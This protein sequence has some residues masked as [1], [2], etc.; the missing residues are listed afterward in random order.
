MWK[1]KYLKIHIHRSGCVTLDAFAS[2]SGCGA[3]AAA[4]PLSLPPPLLLSLLP[5]LSVLPLVLSPRLPLCGCF[6]SMW[7]ETCQLRAKANA[8]PG[9]VHLK[10]FSP[11]IRFQRDG[12][13][14]GGGVWRQSYRPRAVGEFAVTQVGQLNDRDKKKQVRSRDTPHTEQPVGRPSRTCAAACAR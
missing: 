10:G 3:S 7:R 8:H 9:T 14:Q 13:D 1:R 12:G 6:C 4:M 11:L 5:L 2:E